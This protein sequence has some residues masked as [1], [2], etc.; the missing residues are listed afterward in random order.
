[1]EPGESPSAD[2]EAGGPGLISVPVRGERTMLTHL[3]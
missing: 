2:Q 3:L 1:V